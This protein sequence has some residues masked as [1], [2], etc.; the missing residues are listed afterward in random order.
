[1]SKLREHTF[2]ELD[3]AVDTDCLHLF[4]NDYY[5]VSSS[6]IPYSC[7]FRAG[8]DKNF[9]SFIFAMFSFRLCSKSYYIH[10][11]YS[12]IIH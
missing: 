12:N 10:S 11:K 8:L 5:I 6:S 4:V 3:S 1:M 2:N 9:D 7:C